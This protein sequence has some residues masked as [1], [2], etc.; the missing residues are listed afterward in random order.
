[1]AKRRCYVAYKGLR[2]RGRPTKRV[3]LSEIA[4]NLGRE[5]SKHQS[6]FRCKQCD[7]YL[8]KDN[9][10]FASFYKEK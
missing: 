10:Y 6:S 3:V 4:S 1:M 2:Y 8:Y 5:S 7:V 9:S